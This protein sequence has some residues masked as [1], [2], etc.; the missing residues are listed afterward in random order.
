MKQTPD[1]GI[2]RFFYYRVFTCVNFKSDGYREPN[3]F[4]V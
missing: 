4:D 1:P 2:T 3:L